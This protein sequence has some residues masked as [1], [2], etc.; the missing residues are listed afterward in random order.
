MKTTNAPLILY[1]FVVLWST[2][3]WIWRYTLF[4]LRFVNATRNLCIECREKETQNTNSLLM[5]SWPNYEKG[6][7]R[8]SSVYWTF[9]HILIHAQ[10]FFDFNIHTM[11][12]LRIP[13]A[14]Y[15]SFLT[16]RIV[17]HRKCC[18]SI[19]L[20]K[21]TSRFWIRKSI[22]LIPKSEISYDTEIF[23]WVMFVD[24]R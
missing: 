2:W 10:H 6:N 20:K 23:V 12:L 21:K 3:F 17:A 16:N 8:N 22:L 18:Y 24:V 1:E 7:W 19:N 11:N 5:H 14:R 4:R 15:C 9:H 13:F